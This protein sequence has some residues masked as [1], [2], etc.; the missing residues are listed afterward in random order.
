M[1]GHQHYFLS[2]SHSSPLITFV[3]NP[4]RILFLN[5]LFIRNLILLL[6]LLL[7]NHKMF[8]AWKSAERRVW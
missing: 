2:S 3:K 5:L 8:Q 6:F 4:G 7:K 1:A